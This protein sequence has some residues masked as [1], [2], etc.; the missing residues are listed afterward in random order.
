MIRT[1]L[2]RAIRSSK[3]NASSPPYSIALQR[4][5]TMYQ[6]EA[7]MNASFRRMLMV[8]ALQARMEQQARQAAT[9][10][11]T[12]DN[13]ASSDERSTPLYPQTLISQSSS[14]HQQ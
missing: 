2:S 9:C 14:H 8:D 5:I 13:I 10:S 4:S 11:I 12:V 6:M 1:S 3:L 7:E